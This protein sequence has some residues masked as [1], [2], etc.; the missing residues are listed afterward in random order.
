MT[1]FP[2]MPQRIDNL[3]Y[4]PTKLPTR[5][6]EETDL[7]I[8]QPAEF[9]VQV[10]CDNLKKSEHWTRLFGEYI[11]S[12]K[13]TDYSVRSL[14]ALRI[15]CDKWRRDFES[16]YING[17]ILLD[18]IWPAS[19]RRVENQK[20][21]QTLA[22][23]ML[24]QLSS[25]TFFMEID[26]QVPGLNELGKVFSSDMSMGFQ[27]EDQILPLTQLKANFRI[28]LQDWDEYLTSDNRT[29]NDPFER[30]LAD[31]ALIATTIQGLNDE[32]EVQVEIGLENKTT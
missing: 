21:P 9:L 3:Q 12:Y 20:L 32:D 13:R 4:E 22:G 31:L 7:F 15:Y 19:I 17:D 28:N 29:V 5:E 16:W 27:W 1:E 10:L 25:T 11:D 6:P 24:Q 18:I 26:K 30:T 23:A 8:T 2:D 14:P